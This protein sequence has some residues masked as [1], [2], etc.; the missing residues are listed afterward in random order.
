VNSK[1]QKS[2]L[3][4]KYITFLKKGGGLDIVIQY[5]ATFFGGGGG[6]GEVVAHL[7]S[8]DRQTGL[9]LPIKG[10]AMGGVK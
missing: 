5:D 3:K 7:I 1:K 9:Q 4:E 2:N 6:L 10:T 8:L